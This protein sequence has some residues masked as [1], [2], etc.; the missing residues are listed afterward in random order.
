M[1]GAHGSAVTDVRVDHRSGWRTF[2]TTRWSLIVLVIV[3]LPMALTFTLLTRE[4]EAAD[5]PAHVQNVEYIVRH[6]ALPRIS[7]ANGLESHQPPLY[8]VLAAGWQEAL[9]IPAFKPVIVPLP[10]S[11]VLL[12][13]HLLYST[14]YTPSERAD[15]VHVHELRLLSVLIG[16]GTV[17]L[18][19]AAAKIIE[20]CEG[21]ALASGLF[22]ALYPKS[23]IAASTVTND[24]LVIALC[25][26]ALVLYLLSNRAAMR[27]RFDRR[28][29]YVV[30][31][32]IVLGAAALTKLSSLAI[33]V[34]LFAL[35]LVPSLRGLGRAS[36]NLRTNMRLSLDVILAGVGFLA[37]S[38]WWLYRNH[39]LYG[40]FLATNASET[41]LRAFLLRPA[42]WSTH[43]LL[44]LFPNTLLHS[45]WYTQPAFFL[46]GWMNDALAVLAVPCLAVGAWVA[47]SNRKWIS[48]TLTLLPGV[49]L[50]GCFLG[51]IA[52]LVIIMKDTGQGDERDALVALAAIA[53]FAVLGS[54]R[55]STGISP[56]LELVGVAL[57][58]VILFSLDLYI[59]IRFLIPLGGL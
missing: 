42:P 15:A 12:G 45:G 43:L 3:Y 14:A 1:T 47:I 2:P 50:L 56:R 28:R 29:L 19:Y 41:Y 35:A 34:I 51:G 37:V 27:G 9:G 8:Y 32:G 26:L 10:L 55:I 31:M 20:L 53:I 18:T 57:W 16:L 25:A 44:R 52:A 5:E 54:V 33:A 46:P 17:L 6:G 13:N 38:G 11:E 30:A 58:P 22:V 21:W 59:L 49:A 4:Y 24:G 39:H 48:R 7:V 23:L 40:Q 36:S